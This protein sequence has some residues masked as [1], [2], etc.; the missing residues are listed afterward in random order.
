MIDRRPRIDVSL[1]PRLAPLGELAANAWTSWNADARALFARLDRALW[2]AC[3]HSP[4][5]L[6]GELGSERLERAAADEPLV[7]ELSRVHARFRRELDDPGWFAR[8]AASA[9]ML[10]AYFSCEFGLDASL[11]LYSG[12]LGV[13]SGDHLKSASELGVP[14]VAVGLLYREGYF[15]QGLDAKGWQ[16]ERYPLNDP[17]RMGMLLERDDR[18]AP[19][20]IAV[21][22]DGEEVRARIWC[23]PVGRVPLFLLDS[24]V[25]GNSARAPAGSPGRL[26]GGDREMR[27]RQEMLLGVG[28]ARALE[29]LDLEPTVFHIN[30]G[31]S[32]FLAMERLRERVAAGEPLADALRRGAQLDG[33]HHPHARAGRQRGLRARAGP[34]PRPAP[35]PRD[36][37]RRPG[38]A[39]ARARRPGRPVLRHDGPRAA[40]RALRERRQRAPRRGLARD[41]ARPLAG[42]PGRRGADRR[43][44]QRRARAHLARPRDGPPVRDLRHPPGRPAR[45]GPLGARGDDLRRRAVGRPPGP[46]GVPGG[47]RRRAGHA[48]P[49][50]P[51]GPDHRLLP[52]LRHLQARRPAAARP[53]PAGRPGGRPGPAGAVRVRRQGPPG[54]RGRQA[55]HPARPGRL[56]A[57]W[58]A[59]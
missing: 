1:P 36:R 53:G 6:L 19:L 43:R 27:I 34:A 14:L 37:P 3:Q 49:A 56:A 44:D 47:L 51:R 10:V 28:G 48:A 38:A 39:G 21:E 5:R 42:P 18:G 31:H 15:R 25:P 12:G 11:P 45:R 8:D 57:R 40:H 17:V 26:Y 33:L 35:R 22:L 50:R 32:A 24:D 54:R 59:G 4:A 30:E 41:V 58:A 52:A 23:L 13:L 2:R 20:E 55:P 9:D 29:L 16:T 7:A 46:E